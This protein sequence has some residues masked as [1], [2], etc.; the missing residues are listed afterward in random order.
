MHAILESFD[1]ARP[2]RSRGLGGAALSETKVEVKKVHLCCPACVKGV[3][4]ALKGMEGV[5]PTC[6]QEN[7]TISIVAPDDQAAQKML[8]ALA[9]AGYHGEVGSSALVYKKENVPAGKVKSLSVTGIHNCCRSCNTSIKEAVKKVS[10]VTGDTA[11]PRQTA[12]E[13]TGDFDAAEL[14]KALNAAG[15]H[16]RV[17][18]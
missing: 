13:V 17:K 15:F 18:N 9:A 1:A 12:F 10:G 3:G 11:A 6:D 4:A 16:V 5:K 2:V 14:V 8:D 7:G